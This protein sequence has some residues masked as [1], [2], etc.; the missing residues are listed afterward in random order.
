MERNLFLFLLPAEAQRVNNEAFSLRMMAL[1]SNRTKEAILGILKE[2]TAA[3][4]L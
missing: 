2:K 4:F 1:A 3:P